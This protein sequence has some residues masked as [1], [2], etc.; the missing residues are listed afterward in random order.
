MPTPEE[1]AKTEKK[2]LKIE[3]LNNEER[4]LLD[5]LIKQSELKS[6]IRMLGAS[7]RIDEERKIKLLNLAGTIFSSAVVEPFIEKFGNKKYLDIVELKSGLLKNKSPEDN[8]YNKI[9]QDKEMLEVYEKIISQIYHPR[10]AL[11]QIIPNYL[12]DFLSNFPTKEKFEEMIE[13][14]KRSISKENEEY[15]KM[16][17][18]EWIRKYGNSYSDSLKKFEEMIYSN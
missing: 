6:E 14:K 1:I 16:Q 8:L 11:D 12:K 2:G 4:E 9:T 3:D 17:E 13:N 10:R 7:G 18:E 5:L 15:V